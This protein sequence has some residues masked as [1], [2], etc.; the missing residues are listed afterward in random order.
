MKKH[1]L[2][3][4]RVPAKA[5]VAVVSA[6]IEGARL[7]ARLEGWSESEIEVTSVVGGV[8]SLEAPAMDSGETAI[9][10]FCDVLSA[11]VS[12]D[13]ESLRADRPLLDACAQFSRA[14][15]VGLELVRS[16]GAALTISPA[17]VSVL[18]HLRDVT[19]GNRAVR[20]AGD[21]KPET[22]SRAATLVVPNGDTV[23]VRLT[24][25]SPIGRR[26]VVSGLGHFGPSGKCFLID[27]EHVGGEAPGDELFAEV[28]IS[29]PADFEPPSVPQ[30]AQSGVRAF[31]G[32]W[33]G[34]ETGEELLAALKAIR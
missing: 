8:V 23:R 33:P 17:D 20:V 18:E 11:A 27:A 19:P 9:D 10:C 16:N 25:P 29:D 3:V 30:D 31:F 1:T 4:G 7:A 34:D 5:L 2:T 32:T 12:G 26:T 15:P 24:G 28:P 6:I 22:A 13:R 14:C 21:L